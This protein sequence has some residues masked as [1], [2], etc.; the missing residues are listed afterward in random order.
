MAKMS[1]FDAHATE[2]VTLG[3]R[4]ED[5]AEQEVASRNATESE[6]TLG[7]EAPKAVTTRVVPTAIAGGSMNDI[8]ATQRR[9][10]RSEK[11]RGQKSYDTDQW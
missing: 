1:E 7:M 4:V 9:R 6:A 2:T 11:N 3:T 5:G 10:T 8:V